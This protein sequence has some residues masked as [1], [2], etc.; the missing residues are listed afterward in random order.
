MAEVPLRQLVA[1][2]VDVGK[3]TAMLMVCDFAG[4]VLLP[5]V[6]VPTRA[7]AP[8]MSTI[9]RR[10]PAAVAHVDRDEGGPVFAGHAGQAVGRGSLSLLRRGWHAVMLPCSASLREPGSSL[11]HFRVEGRTNASWCFLW[12]F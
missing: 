8:S 1:V 11:S 10:E 6:T 7:S 9:P 3:T 2:P 5:A 12:I 4:R